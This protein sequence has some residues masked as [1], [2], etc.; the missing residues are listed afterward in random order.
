MFKVLRM[1]TNAHS[2]TY[3]VGKINACFNSAGLITLIN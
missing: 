2:N 1:M 3:V